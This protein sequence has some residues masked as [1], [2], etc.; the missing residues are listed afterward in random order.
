MRKKKQKQSWLKQTTRVVGMNPITFKE[1]WR[2]NITK[3]QL[4]SVICL[5]LFLFFILFYLLFSYTPA[6]VLLPENIKNRN[7][8]KIETTINQI[9]QLEE[10]VQRQ[11]LFIQNLQNVILGNIS[12]DSTYS[13]QDFNYDD[14]ILPSDTAT[15]EAEEKLNKQI[16]DVNESATKSKYGLLDDI[17]LFDPVKGTLSQRFNLENHPGVDIIAKKNATIKSCLEGIVVHTSYDDKDGYTIIINHQND[18]TSVY[19]HIGKVLAEVGD[20]V[21][22]GDAIGV[23]GNTGERSSGPHLHF[24]LWSNVGALNP[25]DY[26][27]F[28]R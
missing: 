6:G 18:I 9:E 17:F 14:E 12:V 19:K 5:S 4:I 16:N 10:K 8:Q 23:V 21:K 26:L 3:L 27:S 24:E 13:E 1:S 28:G 25:L 11:E 22:T 20:L 2:F 7:K 15:T